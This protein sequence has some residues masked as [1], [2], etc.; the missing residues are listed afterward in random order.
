MYRAT[1]S[2]TS[3]AFGSAKSNAPFTA[4]SLTLDDSAHFH[5]SATFSKPSYLFVPRS[6]ET[7]FAGCTAVFHC[8]AVVGNSAMDQPNGSGDAA[9]DAYAGGVQGTR[10]VIDAVAA[11]G[12]V[13]R[14]V[15]ISSTGTIY[16][17]HPP[18]AAVRAGAVA[19]DGMPPAGYGAGLGIGRDRR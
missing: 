11:S 7:A 6:F 3:T 9:V 15:F 4:S 14:L 12:S 16:S 19:G 8:A 5:S 2:D 13:R 10:H 17:G 18:V 1:T